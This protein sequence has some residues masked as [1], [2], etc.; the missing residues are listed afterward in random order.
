MQLRH[1]KKRCATVHVCIVMH[2][3]KVHTA[4]L[5]DLAALGSYYIY[6]YSIYKASDP[7]PRCE[8]F[9][10]RADPGGSKAH[11]CCLD[12]QE[13][14]GSRPCGGLCVQNGI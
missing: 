5:H 14:R 8:I 12:L 7:L 4:R 1:T 3:D 10:A 11:G 6:T 13:W 2:I 9:I